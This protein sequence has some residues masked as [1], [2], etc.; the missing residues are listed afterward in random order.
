MTPKITAR[1]LVEMRAA[2][3]APTKAPNVVAISRNIPIRM[4][5]NPSFT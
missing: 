2:R 1:A 3:N 4:F 5:E